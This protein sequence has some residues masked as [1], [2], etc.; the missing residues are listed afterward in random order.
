MAKGVHCIATSV[1]IFSEGNLD[2]MASFVHFIG[3]GIALLAK[4]TT[5]LIAIEQVW[6]RNWK[7]LW[8]ETDS[9]LVV[10]AFKDHS[11][12]LWSIRTSWLNCVHITNSMELLVSHIFREGN[13][14]AISLA[15]ISFMSKSC[16]WFNSI[17]E[18]LDNNY[19]LDKLGVPRFR[20][21]N[22]H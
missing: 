11:I 13:V 1:G 21:S 15:R 7:K 6:K 18:D 19:L 22:A 20:V 2:H 12:I 9:T 8:L 10:K 4:L 3:N 14:C 17:H 5:I 16:S